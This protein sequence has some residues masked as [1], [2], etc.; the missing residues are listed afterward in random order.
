MRYEMLI[1]IVK[2]EI[3]H[4]LQSL[5]LPAI[6]FITVALF[7]MNGIRFHGEYAEMLQE[8]SQN[9]LQ[10]GEKMNKSAQTLRL[11]LAATVDKPPNPLSFCVEG[12][13]QFLPNM[14]SVSMFNSIVGQT[15]SPSQDKNSTLPRF[16][17]IDWAFIVKRFISLFAI[18][19]TYDSICGEKERGTM[20]LVCSNSVSRLTILWGKYIGAIVVLFIPLMI[21]ICIGILLILAGNLNPPGE[22]FA[23][24][25][26]FTLVS[27]IYVSPFTFLG[28][29]I[30]SI[31]HRPPISLLI[32]L[33]IWIILTVVVPSLAGVLADGIADVPSAQE[34]E[35]KKRTIMSVNYVAELEKR[36][37][38]KRLITIEQIKLEA[39]KML[40]EK[41]DEL[42]LWS[43][44]YRNA[45]RKKQD[46]ARN[47]AGIS[48]TGS[49]QS[50]VEDVTDS[51]LKRQR[52]FEYAARNYY[53]SVL[54]AQ[55]SGRPHFKSPYFVLGAWEIKV[56]NES[57]R[58]SLP[59]SGLSIPDGDISEL[60]RFSLPK[61]PLS[62]SLTNGLWHLSLLLLWN[63]ML[64][65][66]SPLVFLRYDVR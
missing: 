62:E 37:N 18:L 31:T 59:P 38:A 66:L 25:T 34:L 19:L 53:Q 6:L 49:F 54:S 20:A 32:L 10:H 47:L 11:I 7:L 63:V 42:V 44:E 55:E 8:Y 39:L 21:G 29:F 65:L 4:H 28:L 64:A 22:T 24:L 61:I 43:E 23:P 1:T 5:K 27:I 33:L 30:S 45:M 16:E 3:M 2:K 58:V 52:R 50:T 36:V 12:G 51:G 56:N 60:P 46:L 9:V 57:V 40:D 26:I 41:A 13:E 15:S 48:P 14:L 17:E 35:I